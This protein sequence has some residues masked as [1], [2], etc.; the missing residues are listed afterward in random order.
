MLKRTFI[1]WLN[2]LEKNPVSK[3]LAA[4]GIEIP[5]TVGDVGK[6]ERKKAEG[7]TYRDSYV[8]END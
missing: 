2:D 1:E 6:W 4:S 7:L 5:E 3:N 8:P